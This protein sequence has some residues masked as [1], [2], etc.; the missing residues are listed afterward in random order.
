MTSKDLEALNEASIHRKYTLKRPNRTAGSMDRRRN[1][2]N[3]TNHELYRFLVKLFAQNS[4]HLPKIQGNF[5]YSLSFSEI[6]A[7]L[8]NIGS[9]STQINFIQFISHTHCAKQVFSSIHFNIVHILYIIHLTKLTFFFVIDYRFV[10]AIL[11]IIH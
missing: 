8:Y 1:N 11:H 2:T 3:E 9:I 7:E 6:S 5:R 10:H 4:S